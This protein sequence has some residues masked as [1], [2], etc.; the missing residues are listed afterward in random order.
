MLAH[1]YAK[2]WDFDELDARALPTMDFT[3]AILRG[4]ATVVT[5]TPEELKQ[6][7]SL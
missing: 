1:E 7:E 5:P 4:Y 2:K 3:E 6:F